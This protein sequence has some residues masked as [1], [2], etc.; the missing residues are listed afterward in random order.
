MKNLHAKLLS[1][2]GVLTCGACQLFPTGTRQE[3]PNEM[4]SFSAQGLSPRL[5]FTKLEKN[6]EVEGATLEI[7]GQVQQAE[8]IWNEAQQDFTLFYETRTRT[9]TKSVLQPLTVRLQPAEDGIVVGDR[10]LRNIKQFKMQKDQWNRQWVSYKAQQKTS[11]L[12]IGVV[13]FLPPGNNAQLVRQ[14][15]LGGRNESLQELWIASP[16]TQEKTVSIVTRYTKGADTIDA[17]TY[18]R[19]YKWDVQ[20]KNL[21]IVSEQKLTK[22]SPSQS[23]FF[24]LSEN[25]EPMGVAVFGSGSTSSFGTFDGTPKQFP[26]GNTGAFRVSLWRPFLTSPVEVPLKR[27]ASPLTEL[28]AVVG[29]KSD[30]E[31]LLITWIQEAGADAGQTLGWLKLNSPNSFE[32]FAKIQNQTSNLTE[33]NLL[34]I[35]QD[36]LSLNILNSPSTK[37]TQLSWWSPSQRDQSVV[38]VLNTRNGGQNQKTIDGILPKPY[39]RALGV[40]PNRG[41]DLFVTLSQNTTFSQIEKGSSLRFCKFEIESGA[42]SK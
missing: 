27:S 5:P 32:D 17:N 14:L 2:F 29:D 8:L 31:N 34:P 41:S 6:C 11:E 16:R 36:S 12:T 25:Q 18:F 24:A 20:N 26:K 21:R 22:E 13:E 33:D 30:P 39:T 3:D 7:Q 23:L 10:Q 9:G 35:E 42:G 28:N 19:W 38:R 4:S 1:T 15:L 40:G 37:S